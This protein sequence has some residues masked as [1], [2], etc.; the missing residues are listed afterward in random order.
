MVL[1]DLLSAHEAERDVWAAFL[2]EGFGVDLDNGPQQQGPLDD[3]DLRGLLT[4]CLEDLEEAR[5][6][7]PAPSPGQGSRSPPPRAQRGVATVTTAT[8]PMR[9]RPS[10][11]P[12]AS[13]RPPALPASDLPA[14]LWCGW[15][16]QGPSPRM[17]ALR[18]SSPPPRSPR[19]TNASSPRVGR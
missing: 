17:A 8:S 16:L 12:T 14:C 7:L 5:A 1:E 18:S 10:P 19:T 9:V 2:H 6:R 15:L 13:G 11:R 4:A 3:E